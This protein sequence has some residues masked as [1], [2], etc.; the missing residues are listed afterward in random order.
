MRV[1]ITRLGHHGDGIADGPIFVP[2]ALP[3]EVIE[4]EVVDGRLASPRI[5]VPSSDRVAPICPHFKSCGGC[6]LQ[7]ASERFVADWKREVVQTALGAQGVDVRVLPTKTSA[8]RSRRRATLSARRTKKGALVGFH[9]RA[10]DTIV[11]IAGCTLLHP[12]LIAA[13]PALEALTVI[14]ASRKGEIAFTVVQSLT[15]VDVAVRGGKAP[16][17]ALR[18]QLAA[19]AGRHKLARL[20]WQDELIA[21]IRAPAQ[22]FGTTMVVPSA[23][24]FLQA[25]SEGEETLVQ[26]VTETVAG[27]HRIV[28]LFSGCGTFSLP[29]AKDSDVHAVESAPEMLAALD[30]GWRHGR[31]LK[32]LTTEGRDLF[33]RPLLPDELQRFDAVVIDP[34]RAGAEAQF[35][36]LAQAR[37]PVIASV[38][39]NPISFARD[40]RILLEAGYRLGRVQPVDQF[41][42]SSHVEIAAGFTLP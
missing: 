4:G 18:T 24:A 10:S 42:W 16:D 12:G 30:R 26:A 23:G 9:A 33:R 32:H 20:T 39:C 29:L 8:A 35:H 19:L 21:E 5:V 41:R 28:D 1:K 36:T 2:M 17:M 11:A 22:R 13:L 25:T 7:H 40:A 31:G 37:V 6:S 34:P 38:S 14:G 3:G 27:A 15:G